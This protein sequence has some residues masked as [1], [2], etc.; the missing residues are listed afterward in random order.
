MKHLILI[1]FLALSACIGASKPAPATPAAAKQNLA[2]LAVQFIDKK[3]DCIALQTDVGEHHAHSAECQL[4][5]NKVVDCIVNDQ[6]LLVC[7][8]PGGQQGHTDAPP[9][10]TAAAP[11]PAPAPAPTPAPTHPAKEPPAKH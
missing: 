8:P 10:P 2:V 1:M 3:A 5:D 6:S 11:A 9:A 7:A 4:S